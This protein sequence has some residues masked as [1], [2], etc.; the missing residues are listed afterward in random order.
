MQGGCEKASLPWA[1]GAN[2]NRPVGTDI[3]SAQ[4]IVP[5]VKRKNGSW[6]IQEDSAEGASYASPLDDCLGFGHAGTL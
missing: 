2:D 5:S 6:G 4:K 3:V 1:P